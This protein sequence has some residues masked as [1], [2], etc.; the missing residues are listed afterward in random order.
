LREPIESQKITI[1]RAG[2]QV[3]FP[4][5]FQLIAA[6][7]PCPCGYL[8]DNE[9]ACR[10]SPDQIKRYHHRLSAPLLDR[11][12]LQLMVTRI[13]HDLLMTQEKPA[14]SSTLIKQTV[15]SAQA[16]AL[17]RQG[18][19][20]AALTPAEIAEHCSL[21]PELLAIIN[22]AA[23]RNNLSLRAI[24]KIIK[25]TR[26]IADLAGQEILTKTSLLEALTYRQRQWG[27]L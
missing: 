16:L 7:N 5:K 22:H 15:S 18:K 1:S 14:L 21:N 6:M 9:H 13:A 20:N 2:R 25:I 23:K 10:C 11:I 8:G 3:D 19:L 27:G 4:A 26:T 12:D 17:Q 24:H